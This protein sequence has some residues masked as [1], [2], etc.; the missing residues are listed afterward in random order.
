MVGTD[1]SPVQPTTIPENCDFY[2]E[3]LLDG[4]NFPTGS[5]DYIQTRYEFFRG[6]IFNDSFRTVG[7]GIPAQSWPPY[8]AEVYRVLKPGSGWATFLEI[9][10]GFKSD[11]GSLSED[12]AINR[13]GLSGKSRY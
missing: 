12:S 7:Q 9:G 1:L 2:I 13:V 3:S 8:I 11:D 4:L 5:V 6:F 10:T